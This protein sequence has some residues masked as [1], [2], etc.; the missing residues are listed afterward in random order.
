MCSNQPL[1]AF[2]ISVPPFKNPGYAL[3]TYR[4]R[5][6]R[7]ATSL[8]QT[9]GRK[10]R[11]P[12]RSNGIYTYTISKLK[13]ESCAIAKMSMRC[14]ILYHL[15]QTAAA[16]PAKLSRLSGHRGETG[17]RNMAATQKIERAL[18]TSY[19]PSIVTFPLS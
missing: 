7:S 19:R 14:T 1:D 18:V 16:I 2:G 11:T 10:S 4:D 15:V 17:S 13:Q 9:V 6:S 3:L 5:C 12:G 8:R